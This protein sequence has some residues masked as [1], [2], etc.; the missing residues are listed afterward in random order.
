MST[1]PDSFKVLRANTER[2]LGVLLLCGALAPA[3]RK[4]TAGW[5]VCGCGWWVVALVPDGWFNPFQNR[6]WAQE[7]C[8]K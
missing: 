7:E 8:N 4:G 1:P 6:L 2:P 3:L 5:C